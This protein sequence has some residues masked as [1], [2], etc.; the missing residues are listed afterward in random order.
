[1]TPTASPVARR[2]A[3]YT[4]AFAIP[5]AIT[6]LV[7][8][9]GLPPFVFEHLVILLVVAVAIS[10][11]AGPSVVAAVVSVLS[12]NVLLREPVGQPA[13]TGYRDVL[14]LVL[15]A[16]VA[17]VISTLMRRAHLAR[18]VAQHAAERE[19]RAREDRDRLVATITHD[20]ATPLAILRNTVHLAR[21]RG[22][23]HEIDLGQLLNRLD[24]ASARAASLLR[25][26]SDAQA[27]E[28]DGFGLDIG[29]HDLVKVITPIVT[30]MDRASERHPLILTLP[31]HPVV[32]RVDA[33]R[34]QRVL[35]NLISNAIKYSPQGGAIEVCV[36]ME[37]AHAVIRVRDRG[38]GIAPD[39]LPQIFN[40]SYRAPDASRHAPG[41]GLGLSIAAEVVHRH[42]G[43]IVA[44]PV[45]SGGTTFEVRLPAGPL[46]TLMSGRNE[47]S[48]SEST[49]I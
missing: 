48:W 41:L 29:T 46:S 22:A 26:L 7:A 8:W 40:R 23:G 45:P 44:L 21:L 1:V 5:V 4:A 16:G 15:F 47:H 33:E 34:L 18:G 10:C 42:G 49:P 14:D 36:C 6:Y 13:I 20:L 39:V 37:G 38:I 27:L 9:L 43:T 25:M 30:M 32:V 31:N 28:S 24:T 35:E 17:I 19:R 12:D 11:G 3:G 2:V